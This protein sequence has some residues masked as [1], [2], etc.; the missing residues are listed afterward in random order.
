MTEE[1]P[2]TRRVDAASLVL[3]RVIVGLLVFVSAARYLAKGWVE[4][5]LLA[6]GFHFRYWGLAWVPVPAPALAY[7]LFVLV[8]LAGLCLAAGRATRTS[9]AVAF[10]AFTWLELVDLSYYLNH[11]YFVSCLLLAFVLVPPRPEGDG[12]VPAWKL[13]LLRTQVGLVYV[14]AGLA[15]LEADWLLAAQPLKIWLARFAELP[16]VGPWMDE[17]W[18]AYA[19]SWSG[20]LFDLLVV[21][22]L[23][24]K[25]TRA[26]AYLALVA[27]HLITGALFPIGVFPWVMVGCA[28]IFFAPDWPRRWLAPGSRLDRPQLARPRLEAGL[29]LAL[30]ALLLVQL[31]LPW[32]QLAYPGSTLWHEQGGRFAYRVMLVEKAGFVEFRVHDRARDRSWR[33]V[34]CDTDLTPLQAKMMSTQPDMIAAYARHL[35]ARYEHEL[36]GAEIE[37]YVDAF[38]AV[39]GRP[40]ARLIDPEVDLAAVDDGLA[41]KPWILPGPEG[42]R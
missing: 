33:V 1:R 39:N 30:A 21:P 35:A 10:L 14:Y 27:F 20:A 22:A 23:M 19:A 9:A 41:A 7:A 2:L 26:P 24:W 5:L 36:P 28:T 40:S 15:K 13:G 42:L 8:A 31:A 18:L 12:R 29:G 34:P 4:E 38:V 25:R 3:L 17:P 37:V 32:R 16:L 6:P 11:Y